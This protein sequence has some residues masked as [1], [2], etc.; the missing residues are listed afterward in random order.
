MRT[1][2]LLS[3]VSLIIPLT[4][5]DPG[6]PAASESP[7]DEA[8]EA[9][10]AWDHE[11]GQTLADEPDVLYD[12]PCQ[13]YFFQTSQSGAKVT[14]CTA[15][16]T[17]DVLLELW[18]GWDNQLNAM[19]HG[20]MSATCASI[21]STDSNGEYPEIG[22]SGSAAAAPTGLVDG[23]D[24]VPTAVYPFEPIV[25]PVAA[26]YTPPVCATICA[27]AGK[28]WNVGAGKFGTCVSNT[29]TSL[30]APVHDDGAMACMDPSTRP[31]TRQGGIMGDCGCHCV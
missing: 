29:I 9:P 16:T 5:C 24:A 25:P 18:P 13:Q 23:T 3:I 12:T 7:Q 27:E 31:W 26:P 22:L 6:E 11:A 19:L 1:P 10:E 2:A 20:S 17:P 8:A 14:A 28:V 15:D 21:G 30:Q 4:A